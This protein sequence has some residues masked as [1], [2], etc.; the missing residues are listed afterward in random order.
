[1]QISDALGKVHNISIRYKG[2]SHFCGVCNIDHV[3]PCPAK[4]AFY[5]EK[6]ARAALKIAMQILAESTL[7]QVDQ[8]GRC[9]DVMCMSGGRAGNV[10]N[11]LHDDRSMKEK[12]QII[13]VAGFND[14]TN[15]RETLDE[16]NLRT[17]CAVSKFVHST[18]DTQALTLVTP[19]LAPNFSN[20][21]Q[22]TKLAAYK[23]LI[24]QTSKQHK[25]VF[26]VSPDPTS[27]EFMGIHPNAEGTAN[28]IH[29]INE[30]MNA[31]LMRNKNFIVAKSIYQGCTSIVKYG[32]ILC[33]E[34]F[35]IKDGMCPPCNAAHNKPAPSIIDTP[36]VPPTEV[37]EQIEAPKPITPSASEVGEMSTALLNTLSDTI[38]LNFDKVK[39]NEADMERPANK[40]TSSHILTSGQN[41]YKKDKTTPSRKNSKKGP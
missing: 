29:Q 5:A 16:F 20:D 12:K 32:C 19:I 6:A 31:T 35:K 10:A 7:R 4:Q 11:I 18:L 9:A 30:E 40:R 15:D 36:T 17:D 27:V 22:R 26:V 39:E 1:M 2:Q 24:T 14:V 23:D 28:I 37:T 34:T 38:R 13:I 3:G 21:L 33:N 41:K 25:N 8:L